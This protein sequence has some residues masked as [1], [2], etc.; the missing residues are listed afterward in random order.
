MPDLVSVSVAL[1]ALEQGHRKVS[2]GL[3]KYTDKYVPPT[4]D[5]C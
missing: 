5:G 1:E 3:L 4:G 2:V